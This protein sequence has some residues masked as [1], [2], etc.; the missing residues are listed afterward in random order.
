MNEAIDLTAVFGG[1]DKVLITDNLNRRLA[2]CADADA[3]D[4]L[5]GVLGQLGDGWHVPDG[6]CSGRQA[7]TQLPPR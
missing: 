7:A 3:I 6:R 5:V 4:R 1:A 2:T